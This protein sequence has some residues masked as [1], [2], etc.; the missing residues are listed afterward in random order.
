MVLRKSGEPSCYPSSSQD[1]QDPNISI[2][3][4]DFLL[5]VGPASQLNCWG[6]GSKVRRVTALASRKGCVCERW[7]IVGEDIPLRRWWTRQTGQRQRQHSFLFGQVAMGLR[8]RWPQEGCNMGRAA[9]LER[10]G[11]SPCLAEK[12]ESSWLLG[13]LWL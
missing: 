5:Q 9:T 6:P 12:Y 2:L 10:F 3:G 1:V 7:G 4:Q 8:L 11:G 13:P